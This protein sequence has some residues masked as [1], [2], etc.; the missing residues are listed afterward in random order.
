MKTEFA[1][2]G[3]DIHQLVR[4][5]PRSDQTLYAWLIHE[6]GDWYWVPVQDWKANHTKG[7]WYWK[8]TLAKGG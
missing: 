4:I 7:S 3:G 5:P 2:I 6:D 8:P 1:I